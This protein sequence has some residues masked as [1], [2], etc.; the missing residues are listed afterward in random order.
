[1]TTHRWL[2]SALAFVASCT[3]LSGA[4][5]L[6]SME[7]AEFAAYTARTGAQ[8]EAIASVA[9]MEGDLA[10]ETARLIASGLEGL[11][12]G[13]SAPGVAGLVGA[14]EL[15]GY[16]ALALV[17]AISEIDA[18]LAEWG[19]YTGEG[20]ARG[21]EVLRAIAGGLSRAAEVGS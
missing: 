11:A 5:R 16:G 4:T 15:H 21:Q 14:L 1:M 13:T 18:Q 3:T 7:E 6:A 2:V 19:A 10:P 9:I 12:A 8:V 17:L 20:W